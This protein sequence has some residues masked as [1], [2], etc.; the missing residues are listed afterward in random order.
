[1][2]LLE[3]GN[4]KLTTP[5]DSL[6]HTACVNHRPWRARWICPPSLSRAPADFVVGK[7]YRLQDIQ[8]S[9]IIRG[10]YRPLGTYGGSGR[11]PPDPLRSLTRGAPKPRSVRSRM[12][13]EPLGAL[14]L[15]QAS[16]PIDAARSSQAGP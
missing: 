16:Y 14:P 2:V 7:N 8:L 11:F 6:L 10:K 9:K 5:S 3:T 4:W 12:S 13:L 1:M 15:D